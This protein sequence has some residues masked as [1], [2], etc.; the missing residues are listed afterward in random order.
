MMSIGIPNGVGE[1]YEDRNGSRWIVTGY[2]T[3][4]VVIMQKIEPYWDAEMEPIKLQGGVRGQ[5]WDGFKKVLDAPKG[6]ANDQP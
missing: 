5:M 2:W 3:D 1:I 4:P 6:F